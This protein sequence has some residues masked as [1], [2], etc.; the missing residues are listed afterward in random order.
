MGGAARAAPEIRSSLRA[1]G[2]V[3]HG[4]GK[5]TVA[6]I[7]WIAYRFWDCVGREMAYTCPT[8]AYRGTYRSTRGRMDTPAGGLF[9]DMPF[10]KF[11]DSGS[12]FLDGGVRTRFVEV[13]VG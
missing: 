12:N 9:V 2:R 6:Y 5:P 8:R 13:S 10:G 4:Q 11:L 7:E 3:V 1:P